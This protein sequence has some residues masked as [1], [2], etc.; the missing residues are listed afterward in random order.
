MTCERSAE[1]GHSTS[2]IWAY[3][4]LLMLAG[5][6]GTSNAPTT[7]S[8]MAPNPVAPPLA[9]GVRPPIAVPVSPG[10]GVE[11][12]PSAPRGTDRRV[13]PAT[14]ESG[15][16]SSDSETVSSGRPPKRERGSPLP[17]LGIAYPDDVDLPSE[18]KDGFDAMPAEQCWYATSKTAV[19]ATDRGIYHRF[20]ALTQPE[21]LCLFYRVYYSCLDALIK[22]QFDALEAKYAKTGRG[23]NNDERRLMKM[24]ETTRNKAKESMTTK[25]EGRNY[26]NAV[27]DLAEMVSDST[28]T[29]VK[30]TIWIQ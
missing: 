21:K 9:P 10:F 15:L 14:R 18:V 28:Q 24:S 8:Q 5:C 20:E 1:F 22:G 12:T 13:L 30:G 7:Y 29:L 25:C 19:W 16:W 23:P 6:A 26:S 2:R 11:P 17:S 4:L 27:K 3:S